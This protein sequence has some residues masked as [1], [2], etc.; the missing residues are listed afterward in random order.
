MNEVRSGA[1]CS[2]AVLLVL[3]LIL[4][5]A[6]MA[7]MWMSQ[8]SVAS[9]TDTSCDYDAYALALR[10]FFIGAIGLM[11]FSGVASFVLRGRAAAL[12]PIVASASMLV[13][14]AVTYAMSR[15]ALDLP[16]FGG[17]VAG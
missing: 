4:T 2:L 12:A 11:L 16:L 9:C 6:A 14:L 15:A 1:G 7:F 8:L 3:Q 5:G 13:F 17:R 10:V